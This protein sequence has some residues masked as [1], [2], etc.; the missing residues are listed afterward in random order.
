M[1][2]YRKKHQLA[3]I[4]SQSK[5]FIESASEYDAKVAEIDIQY[6]LI[7]FIENYLKQ[8]EQREMIPGTNALSDPALTALVA[9]YNNVTLEMMRLERSTNADN[10]MVQQK[11]LQLQLLRTNILT[12]IENA[13]SSATSTRRDPLARRKL[14]EQKIQGI[15]NKGA[16]V[17]R[18][19]RRQSIKGGLH[20]C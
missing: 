13:K 15:P 16:A 2:S 6:S 8:G 10:P 9:E 18:R 20:P 19:E 1:E 4:S 12:S 14:Y 7:L 11:Q 5:L 17:A 3:D